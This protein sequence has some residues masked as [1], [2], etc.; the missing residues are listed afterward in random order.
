MTLKV[1]SHLFINLLLR[2]SEAGTFFIPSRLGGIPVVQGGFQHSWDYI[3]KINVLSQDGK[4]PACLNIYLN[5]QNYKTRSC[6]FMILSLNKQP[7]RA[8]W[9]KI[10]PKW[11]NILR[12]ISAWTH[13]SSNPAKLLKVSLKV[14]K[15]SSDDSNLYI[16]I[17]SNRL[18]NK[19]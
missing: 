12:R 11:S 15:S 7:T 17:Y 3:F 18:Q 2:L 8:N 9:K 4:R 10:H 1:C 5:L 13:P 19:C 16:S 6:L 14:L